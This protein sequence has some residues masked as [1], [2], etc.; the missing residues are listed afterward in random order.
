MP[1]S[2]ESHEG[3]CIAVQI[4][5]PVTTEPCF[6][7]PPVS[8]GKKP[9]GDV[10]KPRDDEVEVQNWVAGKWQLLAGHSALKAV[11]CKQQHRKVLKEQLKRAVAETTEPEPPKKKINLLLVASDSDDE[12]EH[13]LVC[14]A[15]DCY[16]AEPVISMDMSYGIVVE[17]EG[18]Y[19]SLVYL[20]PQ[21]AEAC[22]FTAREPR[23]NP[24]G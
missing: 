15:L 11:S 7:T 4:F 23:F 9:P 6:S 19:E 10:E 13:A 24:C 8:G 18:T 5:V 17:D 22:A 21:A 14:S 16:R 20:S 12:N 1:K 2:R 3:T